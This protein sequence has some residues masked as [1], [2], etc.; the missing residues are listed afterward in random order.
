MKAL[1]LTLFVLTG[2][3]AFAQ[4]SQNWCV[5]K[6][7]SVLR[8][9]KGDT[10]RVAC[11][12]AFLVNTATYRLYADVFRNF[13]ANNSDVRR[14][15]VLFDQSKELYENRIH[16]QTLEYEA[17]KKQFD[18]LVQQSQTI[19]HQTSD[20]LI[21]VDNT[22][23]R[24]DRNIAN[25]QTNIEEAKKLIREEMRLGNKQR[26]KWGIGGLAVGVATTAVVFAIV[27]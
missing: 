17:L 13:N 22:L 10:I 3:T 21:T 8:F 23:N 20:K 25:A 19:V 4:Q 16:Q 7:Y 18:Q 14:L 12:T 9:Y 11:D 24:I 5:Q 15:A 1:F 26:L 2:L 6:D 27:N